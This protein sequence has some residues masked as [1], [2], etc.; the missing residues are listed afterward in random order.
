[1]TTTADTEKIK[2]KRDSIILKT[3]IMELKIETATIRVLDKLLE[4][5]KQCFNEEA[6][7][8]RQI[9][10]L[11]ADYNTIS[12]EAKANNNI[13]GFIIAQAEIEDNRWYGHII[14]INVAPDY[15]RKKV[16]TRLLQTME[17]ILK[18]RS[19]PECRLE[20]REDNI[21]AIKLYQKQ[22]YQTLGKLER[23]YGKKHGVY[24]KKTL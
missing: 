11:L 19:I 2:N 8:K 17:R 21:P 22:G 14:T 7:T 18:E 12:L 20:V 15:R 1:M 5:E 10:Y 24:L 3:D 9:A 4:I 23:Y 6:F 16:A 13:V